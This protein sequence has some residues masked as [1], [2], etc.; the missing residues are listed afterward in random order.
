MRKF[1]L[2]EMD[3]YVPDSGEYGDEMFDPDMND[4]S[5]HDYMGSE[6]DD[7]YGMASEVMNSANDYDSFD[8]ELDEY[9]YEQDADEIE[10]DESFLN[11]IDQEYDDEEEFYDEFAASIP[12]VDMPY[13]EN[14][15]K[16]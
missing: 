11:D 2:K 3:Y 5:N 7:G 13:S 9:D 12:E 15:K 6:E 10:D 1:L 16:Q 4:P 8:S 14:K